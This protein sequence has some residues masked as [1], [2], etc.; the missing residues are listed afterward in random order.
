VKPGT[1]GIISSTSLA[2]AKPPRFGKTCNG[3]LRWSD[4]SHSLGEE[5][6]TELELPRKQADLLSGVS[7]SFRSK[8]RRRKRIQIVRGRHDEVFPKRWGAGIQG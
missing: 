5:D 6:A 3:V 1:R 2:I 7:V 4:Y 8:S